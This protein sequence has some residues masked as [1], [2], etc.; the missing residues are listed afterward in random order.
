METIMNKKTFFNGF[1]LAILGSIFMISDV[2]AHTRYST[3]C[4]ESVLNGSYVISFQGTTVNNE[5][6]TMVGL[7][8]FDG[9]GHVVSTMKLNQNGV[10]LDLDKVAGS[11]TIN[12]NCTGEGL[13]IDTADLPPQSPP[14]T[15]WA[16]GGERM[17]WGVNDFVFTSTTM[18]IMGNGTGKKR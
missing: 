3:N 8:T 11:Y 12:A 9:E 14:L 4:N 5:P 13:L 6:V 17:G 1:S 16:V 18:G 2:A 7:S 10:S 15:I